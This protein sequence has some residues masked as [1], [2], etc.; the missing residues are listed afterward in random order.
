VRFAAAPLHN[1]LDF[2]TGGAYWAEPEGWFSNIQYH[3][4]QKWT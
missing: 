3:S 1:E 4:R 2:R